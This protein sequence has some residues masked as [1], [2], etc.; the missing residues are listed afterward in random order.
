MS[1]VASFYVLPHCLTMP[2]ENLIDLPTS[3][4]ARDECYCQVVRATDVIKYF[5]LGN[6]AGGNPP[7]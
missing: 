6:N 2:A 7:A 1:K 3:S 5:K 4:Q